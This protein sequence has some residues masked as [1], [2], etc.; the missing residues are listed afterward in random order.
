[1]S[2]EH[3]RVGVK[4]EEEAYFALR[5]MGYIMVEGTFVHPSATEK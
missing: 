1:V 4:G 5:R 2:A 3:L